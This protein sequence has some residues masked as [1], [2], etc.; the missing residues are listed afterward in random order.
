MSNTPYHM[1]GIDVSASVESFMRDGRLTQSEVIQ[2]VGVKALS[3]LDRL[4]VEIL[5]LLERPIKK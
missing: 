3:Q 2:K 5:L 4:P 1:A